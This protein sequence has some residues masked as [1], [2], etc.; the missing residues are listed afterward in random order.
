MVRDLKG[1]VDREKAA[2]GLFLTLNEPTRE[3]AR[4]ATTAG[5]YETGGD[6]VPE[7]ANPV[8]CGHLRRS[9]AAGSVRLYGRVQT[10]WARGFVKPGRAQ[11]LEIDVSQ[12]GHLAGLAK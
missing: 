4:E 8:C 2:I 11:C 7:A 5:F 12:T 1:T 6:A 9:P 3:M 10:G